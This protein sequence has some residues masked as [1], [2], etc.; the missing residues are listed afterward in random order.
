MHMD[1]IA[2]I[3]KVLVA[4]R[5]EIAARIVR[6]L[7]VMGIR[8][9]LVHHALDT[10]S[11]AANEADERVE[12]KGAPPVAAYLDVEQ[13]V[14]ACRATGAQAVHPGYGFLS[15]KADFAQAL[16]DAG[17]VF[18]GPGVEAIRAM[19]DKI[20]SKRIAQRTGVSTIPGYT[21][22]LADAEHAA[23][24]AA[25]IGY[26]VMIKAS[27]GGG[28]K[29]MRL[30]R[31]E[32]ECRAGFERASSEA[33]ASFGD[34]RV[35]MERFIERPRHI[36]VQI[37]GDS[38]GNLVHLGEREC[39]IQRR[40]QKVL[41]E[42][43]SPF[44]DEKTRRAMGE[45]ALALAKAVNYCSAGT[46]EFIVDADRNFYFLEMNTRLQVEHPVTEMTTGLD[47]VAEQIRVAEG[48]PLRIRQEDVRLRG[49]AIEV[50][51]YAEDA[52]NGYL[53][54]TG[55]VHVMRLPRGEGIRVDNGIKE[56]QSVSP[57][58]DPM[59]AKIAA[60]GHTRQ[61]AVERLREALRHT[62]VLGVTTN[63]AFLERVLGLR[64]FESGDTH[65]GFLEEHAQRLLPSPP[66]LH[67]QNLLLAAAA[68]TSRRF[69]ARLF[70]I[71]PIS[72]LGGWSN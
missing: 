26:P 69:D 29:G 35:F 55:R 25:G 23:R 57:A 11:I 39:S 48:A 17:I 2:K 10:D 72:H 12:I 5:G 16:A 27:A 13:I 33:L 34:G 30:A 46:V 68:M 6:T 44:I 14:A 64:E 9:V 45:Q 70:S 37:L 66:T 7:R 53:P 59:L 51:L 71:E 3:N 8:S 38:Y 24:V 31:N 1:K 4:N 65:T 15:E 21:D 54:M 67:E 56:G 28:G 19:G 62:V 43:P 60:Y 50:R 61:Q 49:H 47:I 52:D 36:E 20:E 22:E 63:A 40:H 58:F 32:V 41:E 42:S 18:I